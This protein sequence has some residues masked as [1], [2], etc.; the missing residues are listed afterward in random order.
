MAETHHVKLEAT[1]RGHAE[2]SPQVIRGAE[3][4]QFFAFV[5]AAAVTFLLALIEEI[6]AAGFSPLR[7]GLKVLAFAGVGYATLFGHRGRNWLVG[8]LDR[9]K[10]RG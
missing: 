7:F 3:S 9:F 6:P 10:R 4:W 1:A 8:V 2:V 5:F